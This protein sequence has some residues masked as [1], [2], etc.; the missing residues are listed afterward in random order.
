MYAQ[1]LLLQYVD[2]KLN[3]YYQ[4]SK[5]IANSL[6]KKEVRRQYGGQAPLL[7]YVRR[8]P[9]LPHI[10]AEHNP[11]AIFGGLN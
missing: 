9:G 8:G 1:E 6:L 5:V 11:K 10:L 2:H 4:K 3:L 7:I